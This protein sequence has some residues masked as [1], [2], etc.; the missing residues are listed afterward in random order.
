MRH[1][2][3]SQAW[4]ALAGRI[5]MAALFLP[6]AWAKLANLAGTAGFI[7]SKGLPMPMLLGAGAAA[8]EI[9]AAL[10]LVAGWRTRWAALALA[11]FTLLAGV[12][13][14]DFWALP[15]AMAMAQRQAFFKNLGIAGGLLVLAAM[16]PG[17]LSL[18]ARRAG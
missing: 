11:G 8:L 13:F 16:G 17:R 18:D 10:A 4:L 12:L 7:A 15:D 2:D 5:L 3:P 6:S 9:G 1:Q 14:H